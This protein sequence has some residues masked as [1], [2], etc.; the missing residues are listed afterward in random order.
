MVLKAGQA[1]SFQ[2]YSTKQYC[3]DWSC[4]L[5]WIGHAYKGRGTLFLFK[6]DFSTIY[7]DFCFPTK[8]ERKQTNKQNTNTAICCLLE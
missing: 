8:N 4:T 6:N 1:L 5:A 2:S 3:V 7:T